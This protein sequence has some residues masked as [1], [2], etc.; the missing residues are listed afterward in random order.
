MKKTLKDKKKISGAG[1]R[2]I[3]SYYCYSEKDVKKAINKFLDWITEI[4]LKKSEKH[5]ESGEFNKKAKEI[6]GDKLI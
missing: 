3:G 2:R 1:E 5:I 4:S 6:F